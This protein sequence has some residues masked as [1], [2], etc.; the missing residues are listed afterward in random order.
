MQ[1]VWCANATIVLMVEYVGCSV[2]TEMV[3]KLL[4]LFSFFSSHLCSC[5]VLSTIPETVAIQI[6]EKISAK[7]SKV[8]K[9]HS[10]ASASAKVRCT[11]FKRC[12]IL[13]DQKRIHPG[14]TSVVD[15]NGYLPEIYS[16][17]RNKSRITFIN[18]G[19]KCLRI[20]NGGVC[21]HRKKLQ[22][23]YDTKQYLFFSM[24]SRDTVVLKRQKERKINMFLHCLPCN[25]SVYNYSL[26]NTYLTLATKNTIVTQCL[27]FRDSGS[28]IFI[29]PEISFK[30]L[31]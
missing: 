22:R 13:Q 29:E 8:C 20:R 19:R 16:Q 26:F 5:C 1:A 6:M 30:F 18:D 12:N 2:P 10:D 31:H 3:Q 4:H 15:E 14:M 9:N 21:V 27:P 11:A 28:V 7:Q 23:Q 25:K 24:G 17:T